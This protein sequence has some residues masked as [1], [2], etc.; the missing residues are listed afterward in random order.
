MISSVILT[1]NLALDGLFFVA[2]FW[3]MLRRSPG[4]P[5][6][7]LQLVVDTTGTPRTGYLWTMM[8][9]VFVFFVV[10]FARGDLSQTPRQQQLDRIEQMLQQLTEKNAP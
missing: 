10:V 3:T 8:A 2:L 9:G 5:P 6:W 7:P 4:P 1:L